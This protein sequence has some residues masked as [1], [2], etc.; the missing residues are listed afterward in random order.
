M[1][2][3]QVLLSGDINNVLINNK[4]I[5]EYDL[6]RF[7]YDDLFNDYL[8]NGITYKELAIIVNYVCS[9]AIKNN[10]KDEYGIKS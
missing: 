7:Q 6:K 3:N 4:Y 2:Y 10:F 5:Q 9:K 8:N 1:T